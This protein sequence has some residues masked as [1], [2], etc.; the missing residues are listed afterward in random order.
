MEGR[1]GGEEEGKGRGGRCTKGL[2]MNLSFCSDN[3]LFFV[4]VVVVGPEPALFPL[5]SVPRC[6]VF[7][8]TSNF[9]VFFFCLFYC[10]F[11][12]PSSCCLF[13]IIKK[14]DKNMC[15]LCSLCRS[16]QMC[17][18]HHS[19]VLFCKRIKCQEVRTGWQ[20]RV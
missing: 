4:V 16:L 12:F 8:Y 1:G 17:C 18:C 6:S 20:A 19:I 14:N 13:I 15:V 7:N 9:C 2:R 11:C 5:M 3:H 10:V